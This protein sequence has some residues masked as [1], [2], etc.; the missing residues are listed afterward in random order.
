LIIDNKTDEIIRIG[1]AGKRITR[2]GQQLKADS[3]EIE[4]LK[5]DRRKMILI[6]NGSVQPFWIL[7]FFYLSTPQMGTT[8]ALA[9]IIRS[10]L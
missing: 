8:V 6:K 9:N 10:N 5:G 2:T 7:P 1:V 3:P 4:I